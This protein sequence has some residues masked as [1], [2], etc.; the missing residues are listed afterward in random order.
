MPSPTSTQL[1]ALIVGSMFFMEQ[2]DGTIL[3]TALP[4]IAHSLHVDTVATSVALTSYII[5][6]AIFIPASGALADRLGSRTIL[7]LAICI[8][9]G[10]SIFCGR[11]HSLLFL[12][13]MRTIQGIGGALMVPVGRL[14]VIR[15]TPRDQL[16]RTMTW[17]M[18]PA[19]LGP[20]M[21]PVVGGYITTWL[22]WRWNFYLNIP[23]GVIGL[24]LT[25]RY[26][27][28]VR[29]PTPP[30]FDVKGLFLAGGGLAILSVF[31]EL[32]SHGSGSP[33]LV[34]CFLGVGLVLLGIYA[35]HAGRTSFP[36]L[37]LR[38]MRVQTFRI[39]VFG[40]AASRIAVGSL[41][42]LL[43]SFLQIGAGLSAAQS[44]LVTFVAPIGAI[45]MRPFVPALLKRWGFRTILMA[46]G[47]SAALVFALIAA[48]RPSYPLWLLSVVLMLA[49]AAQ[50][51]QFSAYNT[52][53]YADIPA[54]RMSAATSLYSTMQQIMLSAGICIAAGTLTIL[55]KLHHNTPANMT[56]YALGFVVTGAISLFAVPLCATLSPSA[57]ASMSG[58]H[59]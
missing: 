16:V 10:S 30:A 14:A 49:G 20:L 3:A 8:F 41:P 51:L 33:L 6:L 4:A 36:L 35:Y 26:I 19:T 57:G 48:F 43:P 28:E 37:D 21:G 15:S 1:T 50:S 2:L 7:M 11:A 18:L 34:S 55:S 42:F 54:D 27:P 58:N 22:S 40:G 32:F 31:A 46:N 17:M 53:A 38:L 39:S 47:S 12:A 29:E 9:V 23:V 45:A 5:G 24:F 52:V 59:R 25:Y 13:A 44:G 56:D